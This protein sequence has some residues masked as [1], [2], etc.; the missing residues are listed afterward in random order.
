MRFALLVLA[1]R[2]PEVLKRAIPLYKAAG[3]DVFVHLDKKA[4][5][6]SYLARLGDAARHCRLIYRRI[7]IFW[8]GF[9]MIEAELALIF[10]AMAEGQ[11]DR[12]TLVSDDTFPVVPRERLVQVLG[13]DL[14]RVMIRK[15]EPDDPFMSRYSNFYHF[16]HPVSSLLGRQIESAT[17]D[18]RFLTEMASIQQLK[19]RGKKPLDIY[20]GSQW[21]SLTAT[22]MTVVLEALEQDEHLFASFKYSA[23][24][25]EILFQTA[26]GNLVDRSGVRQ[27]IVYVEWSKDPRPYVFRQMDEL[28]AIPSDYCFVRKIGSHSTAILDGLTARFL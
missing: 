14:D 21:W 24:P 11:Y 28:D 23:V 17:V 8:A 10:A 26:V 9:S 12:F 15:L 2:E 4:D 7:D 16:D 1:Y 25:D 13:E 27:G 5:T 22:S 20:Y 18:D 19:D 6:A 3:F